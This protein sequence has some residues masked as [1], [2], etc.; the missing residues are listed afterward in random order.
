MSNRKNG[1]KKDDNR[2]ENFLEKTN[3]GGKKL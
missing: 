2:I 3:K 1:D